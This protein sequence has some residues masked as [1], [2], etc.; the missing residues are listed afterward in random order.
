MV[1]VMVG[2][3]RETT[4][5]HP[6]AG[7]RG[8]RG[9][10]QASDCRVGGYREQ[11]GGTLAEGVPESFRRPH[12][13]STHTPPSSR[14]VPYRSNFLSRGPKHPV[15]PDRKPLNPRSAGSRDPGRE[16]ARSW[17][18]GSRLLLPQPPPHSLTVPTHP[19]PPRSRP[20]LRPILAPRKQ[21]GRPGGAAGAG[22]R[23]AP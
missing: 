21:A 23:R 10:D 5:S 3:S 16:S 1:V 17:R 14:S 7:W 12:P 11:A 9:N 8:Q 13:P 18:R 4:P 20:T 6:S 22:D 2:G 19:V 15:P